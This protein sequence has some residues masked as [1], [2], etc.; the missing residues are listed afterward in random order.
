[1]LAA[2]PA[3]LAMPLAV[4]ALLRIFGGVDVGERITAI[5]PGGKLGAVLMAATCAVGHVLWSQRQETAELSKLSRAAKRAKRPR[6]VRARQLEAEPLDAKLPRL[7]EALRE[8]EADGERLQD[9]VDTLTQKPV[10]PQGSVRVRMGRSSDAADLSLVADLVA[11]INTSYRQ[12][13]ADILVGHGGDAQED[14]EDSEED[15]E[16]AAR[17]RF[18]RTST[19]EVVQ[20]LH[21]CSDSR[22]ARKLLLAFDSG[23]RCLGCCSVTAPY[24]DPRLGEWG[25]V[26][27]AMEAQGRGVGSLLAAAAEA[28]CVMR[29]CD[30]IQLEYFLA[31]HH[32]YSARLRGWYCDKL[33]YQRVQRRPCGN[34]IRGYAT[35]VPMYFEIGHKMVSPKIID[36]DRQ[37]RLNLL[38]VEEEIA[39]RRAEL[40]QLETLATLPTRTLSHLPEEVIVRMLLPLCGPRELRALAMTCTGLRDALRDA[41]ADDID[42]VWRG[43]C[44]SG[45]TSDEAP[46]LCY[47]AESLLAPAESF[48][49]LRGS[50]SIDWKMVYRLRAVLPNSASI[51]VDVGRG[52]TR[53]GL[54][55]SGP[56][57]LP[58]LA[59][60]Q[61]VTAGREAQAAGV[62]TTTA[63]SQPPGSRILQLCSSPS[64]PPDAASGSQFTELLRRVAPEYRRLT[65]LKA[66]AAGDDGPLGTAA[67]VQGWQWP[68]IP[69]LEHICKEVPVLVGEPFWLLKRRPGRGRTAAECRGFAQALEEWRVQIEQQCIGSCCVRFVPQPY[70]AMAAHGIPAD[71]DALVLNLGMRECVAVAIVGG[72]LVDA[73]QQDTPLGGSALTMLMMRHLASNPENTTWLRNDDMTWCRDQKERHCFVR[74]PGEEEPAPIEISRPRPEALAHRSC[75]LGRERW[76]VPEAL[77]E[78]QQYGADGRSIT[79]ILLAAAVAAATVDI[80]SEEA[81]AAAGPSS[82]RS[83]SSTAEQQLGVFE[84]LLR[85]I[86]VVGGASALP[87]LRRRIE[88]EVVA[89]A[90][91][92]PGTRV[93]LET[94][95]A[96]QEQEQRRQKQKQNEGKGEGADSTPP[97]APSELTSH[98]LEPI[99]SAAPADTVFQGGCVLSS[100]AMGLCRSLEKPLPPWLSRVRISTPFR[101]QCMAAVREATGAPAAPAC[102]STTT[103]TASQQQTAD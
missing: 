92:A 6:R 32:R 64:H 35:S 4:A 11:M 61:Q 16:D 31:D 9:E 30:V 80:P 26:C 37:L 18:T 39:E 49:G 13:Y 55:Q 12:G 2:L 85:S 74:L 93:L 83:S 27:V 60:A 19:P 15:E 42:C 22:S 79:A 71:G 57:I 25:L 38:G 5:V 68:A 54:T 44:H 72:E 52:Y 81:G 48:G 21:M 66:L 58:M 1:M 7:R 78:P 43:I 28:H 50:S 29:G 67:A 56:G 3:Q 47:H 89:A 46:V 76:L 102:S 45:H 34:Q 63:L 99:G 103:V 41:P 14:S 75:T 84:R 40:R 97:S 24:G 90:Q 51:V 91:T 65:A 20:R 59:L 10:D 95:A 96:R 98:A 77:F 88:I 36:T 101:E 8:A 87:N 69:G 82:S 94:L 86:I 62:A 23:R 100:S 17:R 53:F 33:G 70:M 73:S